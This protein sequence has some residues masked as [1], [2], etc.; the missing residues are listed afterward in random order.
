MNFIIRE[1]SEVFM[2]RAS[3]ILIFA[4]LLFSADIYAQGNPFVS[5]EGRFSI[6]L[7]R[8]PIEDVSTVL[9]E[10][11][12]PGRRFKWRV[13]EVQA[14]FVVT[15]SDASWAKKEEAAERVEMAA[16]GYI[17]ALP[18]TAAVTLRRNMTLDGYPGVEVRAREKD[19]F[20]VVNRYY[21]ANTRLYCVQAMWMSGPQD[22]RVLN[23]MDSF[24]IISKPEGGGAGAPPIKLR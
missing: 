17:G 20:V 1:F 10:A 7:P 13:E 6:A 3:L 12:V 4:A 16:D 2:I 24:K 22:T 8:K 11:K 18:G 5:T 23:I 15:Y 19:G 21:M 9:G 14:T